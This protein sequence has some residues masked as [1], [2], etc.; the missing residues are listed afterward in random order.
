[1]RFLCPQGY[2]VLE[3]FPSSSGQETAGSSSPFIWLHNMNVVS[4]WDELPCMG[5]RVSLAQLGQAGAEGH[6]ERGWELCRRFPLHTQPPVVGPFGHLVFSSTLV[7]HKCAHL[8]YRHGAP[9]GCV[10]NAKAPG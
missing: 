5:L 10:L 6:K 7:L 2:A 8:L 1:M 9:L 3:S 4:P